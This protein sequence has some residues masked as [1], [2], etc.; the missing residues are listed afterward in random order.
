MIYSIQDIRNKVAPIAQKYAIPSVYL[1]GSYARNEANETSDLDFLIDR[2][3]YKINSL[4]DLGAV[5][6]ELD[7][8]FET[9]IDIVTTD[10]LEQEDV[11]R[12]TPKL[13][14]NIYN[15]RIVIYE[16]L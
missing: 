10:T 5:Y 8:N 4:F 14:D 3:N 9:G 6:D 12:R 2:H 1:F 15:D 16:Q 11:K 7:S 13:K